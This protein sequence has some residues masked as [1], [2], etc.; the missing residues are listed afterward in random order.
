DPPGAGPLTS[1]ADRLS[2]PDRLDASLVLI[3]HGESEMIV[4]RRFQG[5]LE[6]PLSAMGRRQA[7]RVATRLARPHQPPAL[8]LPEGPPVAIVHSPLRRAAE[9]AAAI[10]RSSGAEGRDVPVRPDGRFVEIS[11]GQWEGRL[12]ADIQA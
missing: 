10:A 9:T 4:Q 1:A 2:I 12:A 6:T 5:R 8:P 3:R 11:Q 7:E